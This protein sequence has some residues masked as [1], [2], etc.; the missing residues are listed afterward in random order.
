MVHGILLQTAEAI[1]KFWEDGLLRN[2]SFESLI[3]IGMRGEQDSALEG[4]EKENIEL[5]K[6]IILTQK[7]LL[8]ETRYGE[9]HLRFSLYI[10]K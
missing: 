5:L 4:S 6:K 1:T 3:T 10:K 7:S 9:M 8:K 2:R